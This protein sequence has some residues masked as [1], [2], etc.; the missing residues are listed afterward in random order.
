M[1]AVTATIVEEG[2]GNLD[3]EGTEFSCG[4]PEIGGHF[5]KQGSLFFKSCSA[6][7]LRYALETVT[8][9]HLYNQ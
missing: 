9:Y 2:A 5:I 1:P 8:V 7:A 4:L 6:C 3:D